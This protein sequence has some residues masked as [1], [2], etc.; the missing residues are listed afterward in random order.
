MAPTDAGPP[1]APRFACTGDAALEPEVLRALRR[2]V[3]PELAVNIVE[4]GLVY[5][6]AVTKDAV[7]VRI[8]MTS[9]ACPVTEVIVDDVTHELGQALDRRV[10]VEVVW[11]PPWTHGRM[12]DRA[13]KVLDF[14]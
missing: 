8:T 13:R 14:E 5:E 12:S 9:P 10:E 3:D 4:L 11:D 1:E 2:V 6:V 7:R